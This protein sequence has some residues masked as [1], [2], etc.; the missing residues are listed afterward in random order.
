MKFY[1]NKTY[2]NFNNI[3]IIVSIKIQKLYKIY[4]KDQKQ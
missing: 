1:N 3:W 4:I 2:N